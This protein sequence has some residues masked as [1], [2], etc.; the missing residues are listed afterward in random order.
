MEKN[1]KRYCLN[2]L[3]FFFFPLFAVFRSY[4]RCSSIKLAISTKKFNNASVKTSSGQCFKHAR[5]GDFE[6]SQ[7]CEGSLEGNMTY[8]QK[9][10]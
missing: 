7:S 10:A 3:H 4:L 5:C 2:R 1:G 6:V 9:P 8:R